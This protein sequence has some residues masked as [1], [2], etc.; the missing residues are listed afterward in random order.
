MAAATTTTAVATVQCDGNGGSVSAQ[1]VI[2]QCEAVDLC[3]G[4]SCAAAVA[5]LC[6]GSGV[7][8]SGGSGQRRQRWQ[9]RQRIC[10]TRRSNLQT[11]FNDATMRDGRGRRDE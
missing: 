6:S 3:S 2:W 10:R 7:S 9:R 1:C 11:V 4:G 5:D 8:G